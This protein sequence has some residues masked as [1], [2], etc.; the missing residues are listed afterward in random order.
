M[1]LLEQLHKEYDVLACQDISDFFDMSWSDFYLTLA[2]LKRD[3][4]QH[5]ERMVFYLRDQIDTD[6]LKRFL[7]DFFQQL[8]VIDIPNFFV[9]VVVPGNN[10]KDMTKQV[11]Q[12][13]QVDSDPTILVDDY[14]DGDHFRPQEI[15][16]SRAAF[17]MPSTVC[18]M[19]WN[20]LDINPVG[21]FSPCCFYQEE[22]LDDQGQPFDPRKH[23]ISEVYNSKYM[24]KLRQLFREGVRLQACNRCWKEEESGTLSK[25]QLYAMRWGHDSRAINWEED[26]ER[27]LKMLSV[28]FGNTC[29]LKCRIC[30]DKSSSKIAGEMLSNMPEHEKKSSRA[31]Y[32][33]ERGKW[34]TESKEFW[35]DPVLEQIKYFDFA[36]G[37]PLLDKN[38][39]TALKRFV[40]QGTAGDTTIHYNTNGTIINDDLL[41][42]W[43]HF[44]KIDLAVS[45]DDIGERFNY[46]RPGG[47][48]FDWNLVAGNVSYIKH[49]KSPN[50]VLNLHCAVSILNVFYLPDLCDWIET[51]GFEDLH[52]S[53]L[54][55]PPHLSILNMP[56]GAAQEGVKIL[57]SH[58]FSDRVQPFIDTVIGILARC[59]KKEN[60]EFV[61]HMIRLDSIRKENISVVQPDLAKHF[62]FK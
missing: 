7:R 28:A 1:T 52:F 55:N 61:E 31:W 6:L 48:Q 20:S 12:E 32:Y 35:D 4:Y 57:S 60:H 45:I 47:P 5:R 38:H 22:I 23:S 17:G 30:S 51:A 56:A 27:N 58:Q 13:V 41:E 26:D 44:K 18:P 54:Y 49:N 37:E 10:E 29:N 53:V 46:Q 43:K 36:G 3:E 8:K 39:L 34:I 15:T 24:Q 33:L 11:V 50:V 62:G 21:G 19:P 59:K 2:S 14:A 42:I 16:T 25:R 9:I 40:D